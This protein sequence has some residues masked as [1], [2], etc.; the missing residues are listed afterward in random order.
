MFALNVVTKQLYITALDAE[1]N[2]KEMK[3]NMN[4]FMIKAKIE[5]I[6]ELQKLIEENLKIIEGI[7]DE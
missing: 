6:R 7:L 3:C 1:N 4:I 2:G 5:R